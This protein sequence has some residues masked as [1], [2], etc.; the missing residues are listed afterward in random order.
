LFKA[1]EGFA[2]NG[3]VDRVEAGE[4]GGLV[5]LASQDASE[6]RH[7]GRPVWLLGLLI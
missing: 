6:D 5:A 3:G 2:G 1:G 4:Q 7:Q